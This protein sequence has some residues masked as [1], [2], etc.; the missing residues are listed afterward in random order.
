MSHINHYTQNALVSRTKDA[1][2]IS[3]EHCLIFQ[4]EI[5][6]VL[7]VPSLFYLYEKIPV[8]QTQYLIISPTHA[9]HDTFYLGPTKNRSL[10]F[11]L[12]RLSWQNFNNP[13]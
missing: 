2:L 3:Q 7:V 6:S 9:V 13:F 1:I 5:W 10:T 4:A 11:S 8:T 12:E